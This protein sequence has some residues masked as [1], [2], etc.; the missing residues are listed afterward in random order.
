MA[1]TSSD[2]QTFDLSRQRIGSVYAKALL[3]AADDAGQ[4]EVV[5]DEFG[6]LIHDVIAQ[7]DDLRHVISGSILSEEQRIAVLDK[8][9]GDKMNSVLL[10]FLKVVTQ[11][12]RQNCLR[13]IYDAAVKLNNERLGLVEV[14]AK[15]A[16]ELPQELSDSL[17]ASLKAKLGREVVLKSE[18]DPSVIGGLVLHVG[19]TV[20]DGS[21]ANRLKQLRQK[22]LETTARQAKASL[23]RFTN[24]TQS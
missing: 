16:T 7:R 21:V 13:E 9:F 15:T 6:S 3:G 11:H 24:S 19:D 14:T 4:T 20:F 8:A 12:D 17:T 2:K 23:E 5:L 1:G 22:A 18:V 10:T